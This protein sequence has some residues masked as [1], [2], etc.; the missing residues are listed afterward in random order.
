MKIQN[1]TWGRLDPNLRKAWIRESDNNKKSIIIQF[2]GSSKFAAPATKNHQLRTV[3]RTE[4][5]D[6]DSEAY[7]SDC[8]ANSEGTY[9]FNVHSSVYDTTTADDGSNGESILEGTEL[10]VNA[11]AAKKARAR[12]ILIGK[13]RKKKIFKAIEM[14]AGASPKMMASKKLEVRDPVINDLVPYMTYAAKMATIDYFQCDSLVPIEEPAVDLHYKVNLRHS[15]EMEYRA[16][17][18][19]R[20][21]VVGRKYLALVDGGANGEI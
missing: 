2:S 11:A 16:N 8:T 20:D 7:Y 10:N 5:E 18:S 9:Q 14:P 1:P 15:Y 6:K 13:S 3:Y 19:K 17:M 21:R 4:F 12:S